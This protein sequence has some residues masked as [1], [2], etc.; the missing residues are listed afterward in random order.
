MPGWA[1]GAESAS[2]LQAAIDTATAGRSASSVVALE[3]GLFLV[4][5]EPARFGSELL[6]TLTVA[7]ALDDSVADRLARVTH[8]DV[9][10][11]AAGHLYASSLRGDD[12]AALAALVASNEPL[13]DGISSALRRVGAGSYVMGAFPLAAN[14]P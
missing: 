2:A 3:R 6:G 13:S 9:S 5:A 4:V 14:Q 7:Y 1:E 8:C 10:L 11:A 12:R